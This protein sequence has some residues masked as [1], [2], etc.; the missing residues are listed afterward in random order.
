MSVASAA[1]S[2]ASSLATRVA[3]R[4]GQRGGSGAIRGGLFGR[5]NNGSTAVGTPA[6]SVDYGSRFESIESRLQALEGGGKPVG[7]VTQPSVTPTPSE[8]PGEAVGLDPRTAALDSIAS[9]PKPQMG[10]G[11]AQASQDMFGTEFMRNS[12]VGAAKMI[13]NKKI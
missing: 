13:K 11:L 2:A 5:R 8:V 6:P 4:R 10:A 9:M 7:D 3:A 1:G 12:A